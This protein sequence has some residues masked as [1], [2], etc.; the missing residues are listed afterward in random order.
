VAVVLVLPAVALLFTLVQRSMV[1][2]TEAPAPRAP[3]EITPI[4]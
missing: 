2:E 3:G 1:E 4:G